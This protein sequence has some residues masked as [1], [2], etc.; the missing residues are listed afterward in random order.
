MKLLNSKAGVTILE[1]VI[2]LG[3]LAVVTAGAFGVLASAARKSLQPD[4]REEMA[5]AV[6]KTKNLLQMYSYGND[7]VSS[8]FEGGLCKNNES[9]PLSPGEHS[10]LCMLPPICDQNHP[11]SRFTYTVEQTYIRP[12]SSDGEDGYH[13][14]PGDLEEGVPISISGA[15]SVLWKYRIKFNMACNGYEL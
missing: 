3:L 8:E 15:S 9:N 5:L 13:L 10:I 6:E 12:T 2:A 4:M 1:G 14:K 7:H 11:Q